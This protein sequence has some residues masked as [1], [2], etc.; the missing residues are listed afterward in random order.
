MSGGLTIEQ[1]NVLARPIN[2]SRVAKR[3]GGG[4][5][6]LSY[7][8]SWDVRAHLIRMFGYCNYDAEVTDS[9]LVFQ[10]DVK[11]GEN[12][13]RDGWEVAYAATVRLTIRDPKGH[14]LCRYAESAVGS[15]TGSVGL[16]DLHDNALKTAASDALKRCAIN[17]GNQFGLS[18]YDHG[19]TTDVIK[20]TLVTPNGTQPV[21]AD[22]SP[23]QTEMLQESLGAEIINQTPAVAA[24]ATPSGEQS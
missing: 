6:Q 22:L 8:E 20:R 10:R 21:N 4:G 15:E 19:T 14:R 1:H 5:K 18:L 17:L 2:P 13:D 3:S 9:H 7:L 11:L 24:E 23:A 16:G 12:K